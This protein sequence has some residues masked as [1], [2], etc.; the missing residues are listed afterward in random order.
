[1]TWR[2]QVK[3]KINP[4]HSVGDEEESGVDNN[5]HGWL[6]AAALLPFL[7]I[8]YTSH[9][10]QPVCRACGPAPKSLPEAARPSQSVVALDN[11]P[12][13]KPGTGLLSC[14]RNGWGHLGKGEASS[15]LILGV[16]AGPSLP[17]EAREIFTTSQAR[18]VRG[19]WSMNY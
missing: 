4:R 19:S 8:H 5:L 1:M 13:P 7:R 2:G 16:S 12:L 9:L 14:Q 17:L 3:E 15:S 6:Q 11:P 18:E 10:N